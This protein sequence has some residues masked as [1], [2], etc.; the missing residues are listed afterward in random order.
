MYFDSF[1]DFIAM[2]GHGLY[3]WLCYGIAACV[4]SFNI[5]SPLLKK[6]H[7]FNEQTRRLRR[8]RRMA[9]Q[10]QGTP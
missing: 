10:E 3:V 4:L 5:L 1:A 8:E 9:E 2:G 7:F 6:R